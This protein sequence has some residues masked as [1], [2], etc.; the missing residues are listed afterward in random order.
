[1]TPVYVAHDPDVRDYPASPPFDPDTSYPEYPYPADVL[2]SG[3]GCYR[4]V[5]DALR[6]LSPL[7]YGQPDWNPLGG[8]IK[9]GDRVL[10]KPNLVD[11]SAWKQ[12][13]MTH[14]AFLRPIIDYAVKACS[15]GGQVIVGEGPWAAGVFDRVVKNTGI[16]AMVEHLA[17]QHGAPVVLRD[18]NKASR[19]Q[20]PLVD[21][22]AV[23]ALTLDERIWLDA[24]YKP[25]NPG[26]EL[27]AGPYLIA[28]T[29]LQADVVIS[30]PK[31]KVHCSGGITVTMKNMLGIIPAWD[32]HYEEAVLKDCAHASKLDM[33]QGNHGKYLNNDTIWRSMSDL[34]RILLYADSLGQLQSSRQRRYLTIVDG[35]VG[36]EESQYSPNPR[37][38]STVIV[39]ADPVTCDAISARVMG[40]DP[41]KLRSVTQPERIPTHPLGPWR[42]A[43]IRLVTSWGGCLNTVYR[44]SLTPELHVYSWQ[45]QVE[46]DDFDPPQVGAVAWDAET[47][48]LRAHI[49]DRAGVSHARLAYQWQN[50]R[51]VHDLVL[52]AGDPNAGQWSAILPPAFEVRQGELSIGDALFNQASVQIAW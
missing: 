49:E 7:G 22:G 14:P 52:E 25:M 51:Y 10:I 30:V 29:V 13:Q 21:L 1:M 31:I 15:P 17:Q 33:E 48:S 44:S 12:G 8:I 18:L 23:S 50:Q 43:N 6:L 28:P 27:G 34:N 36:A 45:G 3:N 2:G 40:F 32:G 16:Q 19:E 42:P 24:H 35:I 4:L 41:R 37:P 46:A 9:P 26:G 38:L 5:R 47:G 20:T 11:D 39:S